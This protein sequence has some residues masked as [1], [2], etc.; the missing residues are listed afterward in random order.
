MWFN[1]T[2][3]QVKSRVLSGYDAFNQEI[4]TFV[5]RPVF[6]SKVFPGVSNDEF[7]TNRDFVETHSTLYVK[8]IPFTIQNNDEIYFNGSK[9]AIEGAVTRYVHDGVLWDDITKIAL[10]KVD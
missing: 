2:P 4:W 5:D 10:K 1:Q 7:S 3:I 6:Y 8:S 9:W